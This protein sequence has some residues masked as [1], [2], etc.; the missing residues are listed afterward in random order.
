MLCNILVHLCPI[1][2]KTLKFRRSNIGHSYSVDP[3]SDMLLHSLHFYAICSCCSQYLKSDNSN[4]SNPAS[5]TREISVSAWNEN[6]LFTYK[7]RNW[8]VRH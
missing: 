5:Q 7:I 8:F 3:T 1:L 4:Q 2:D 6:D